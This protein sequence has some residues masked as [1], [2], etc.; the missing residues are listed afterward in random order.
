MKHELEKHIFV[1]D[2]ESLMNIMRIFTDFGF[3]PSTILAEFYKIKNY[4]IVVSK[5]ER[6]LKELESRIKVLRSR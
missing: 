5:R 6:K 4:P 2:V 1:S 3:K